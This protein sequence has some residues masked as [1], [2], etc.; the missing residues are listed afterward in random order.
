MLSQW[1]SAN[2]SVYLFLIFKLFNLVLMIIAYLSYLSTLLIYQKNL[3][4]CM[5]KYKPNADN[6]KQYLKSRKWYEGSSDLYFD[7]LK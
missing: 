1:T 4:W 7:I 6:S 3:F 2:I 5:L